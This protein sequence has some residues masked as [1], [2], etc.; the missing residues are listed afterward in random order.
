MYKQEPQSV[1]DFIKMQHET[2]NDLYRQ[3][4]RVMSITSILLIVMTCLIIVAIV[5]SSNVSAYDTPY[6]DAPKIYT[7]DG[8]YMG[9]YSSDPRGVDSISNPD[10]I[11]GSKNSATNIHNPYGTYGGSRTLILD[12]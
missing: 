5:Y 12:D 1:Q 10:G 8:T 9:V 11:Y 3:L 6:V 2:I 7:S 4:S